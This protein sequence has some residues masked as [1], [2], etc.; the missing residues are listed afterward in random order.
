[1]KSNMKPY[2]AILKQP[3]RDPFWGYIFPEGAIVD[4]V[5][6]EKAE[7]IE[8]DTACAICIWGNKT[9]RIPL[10]LLEEI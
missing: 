10:E 6:I 2:R 1:M 9:Q 8:Y 4:V 3:Y 7:D 5:K